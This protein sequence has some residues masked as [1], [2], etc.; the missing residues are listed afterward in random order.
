M[1][2]N[3]GIGPHLGISQGS[4]RSLGEPLAPHPPR[5]RRAAPN[6]PGAWTVQGWHPSPWCDQRHPV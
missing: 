4:S 2:R 5:T 1:G 6:C 3:S